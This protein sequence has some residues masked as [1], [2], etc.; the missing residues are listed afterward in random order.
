VRGLVIAIQFLT[1]LPSP[2]VAADEAAFAASMRWFPV[3]GLIVGAI[4]AAGGW[5]GALLDPWLGALAALMLWV[6]VTG[7][8]HLDG[9]ADFAD[10]SGAAHKDRGRL[11]AVLSDPHVGSFGVVAI[12]LQLIAKA[13]LLHAVVERSLF[14]AL[15]LIPFAA[16]IGTL[17]WTDGELLRCASINAPR[18]ASARSG[19]RASTERSSQS[20][21]SRSRDKAQY[22]S[23]SS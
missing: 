20:G 4:V 7:A 1:R 9:L 18:I 16:R 21:N 19:C 2:R 15:F 3:V 17:V 12:V 6:G 22:H 14:L 13:V 10:A 5:A 23:P 8:L 11:L